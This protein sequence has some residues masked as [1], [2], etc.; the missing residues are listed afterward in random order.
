MRR[1]PFQRQLLRLRQGQLM[2]ILDEAGETDQFVLQGQALPGGIGRPLCCRKSSLPRMMVS[3]VRSSWA[4][5]A[6]RCFRISSAF[7]SWLDISLNALATFPY[8]SSVV[9]GA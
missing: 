9:T 4:T 5:S 7:F 8:S 2:K 1:F 6:T 3:G